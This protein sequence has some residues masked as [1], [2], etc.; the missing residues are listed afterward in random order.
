MNDP[1]SDTLSHRV[2]TWR[3]FGISLLC[4]AISYASLLYIEL[5]WTVAGFL[6]TPLAAVLAL[7]IVSGNIVGRLNRG[8]LKVWA[9]ILTFSVAHQAA[10]SAFFWLNLRFGGHDR[11]LDAFFHACVAFIVAIPAGLVSK[12][13]FFNRDE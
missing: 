11:I 10:T 3:A 2:S 4:S 1:T 8:H 5:G 13:A 12:S 7:V 9:W 6:F